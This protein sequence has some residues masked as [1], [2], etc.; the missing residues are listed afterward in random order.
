MEAAAG[1]STSCIAAFAHTLSLLAAGAGAALASSP[2]RPLLRLLREVRVPAP[3][4]TP[5]ANGFTRVRST[6]HT[7]TNVWWKEQPMSFPS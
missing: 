3:A 4:P 1:G 7:P 6:T 2:D 5:A